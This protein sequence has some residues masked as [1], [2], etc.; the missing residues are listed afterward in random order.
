MSRW[1]TKPPSNTLSKRIRGSLTIL[2]VCP[3]ESRRDLMSRHFKT[4]NV[5]ILDAWMKKKEIIDREPN[6][7]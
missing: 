3:I 2:R 4:Q 5:L 7:I 6:V 1:E